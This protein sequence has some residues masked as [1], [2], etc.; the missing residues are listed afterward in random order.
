MRN[1]KEYKGLNK[2]RRQT[3]R[4]PEYHCDNCKCDRYSPCTCIR[5]GE[6]KVNEQIDNT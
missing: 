3:G 5:K 6:K 4:K 2:L 1:E